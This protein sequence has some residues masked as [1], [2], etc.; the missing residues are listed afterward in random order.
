MLKSILKLLGKLCENR[1]EQFDYHW[2][3]NIKL[4]YTWFFKVIRLSTLLL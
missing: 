3:N 4:L 1:C 2:L